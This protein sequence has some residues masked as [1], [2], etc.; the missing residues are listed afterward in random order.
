MKNK[1]TKMVTLQPV[2]MR[3]FNRLGILSPSKILPKKQITYQ[4]FLSQYACRPIE[5]RVCFDKNPS[6][7]TLV[8]NSEMTTCYGFRLSY[9]HLA[10]ID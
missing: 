6:R 9:W 2:T 8:K 4:H 5:L 10:K 3:I 7:K 1:K